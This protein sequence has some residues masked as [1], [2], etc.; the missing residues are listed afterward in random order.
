VIEHAALIANLLSMPWA[1]EQSAFNRLLQIADR[2]ARGES[3]SFSALQE[4]ADIKA[5]RNAR[6]VENRQITGGVG[7][8]PIYGVIMQRAS[9]Y[10]DVSGLVSTQQISAQLQTAL[11]DT[12]VASIVLEFDSPGGSVFGIQ[13]LADEIQLATA[14]K[15]VIGIANSLAASAA[16]WLASQ[17]SELYCTP[18][19]STGSIGVYVT[20]E[21]WS[22]A[23]EKAGV[24]TTII[25]AGKYKT[26]ASEL[27]P[28]SAD[29]K[30]HLQH[31]VDSYYQTFI[32]Q[33]GRGRNLPASTVRR[34]MGEGRVLGAADARAANMIDGIATFGQVINRARQA[35]PGAR[36]GTFAL[37]DDTSTAHM[38][39]A[40]ARSAALAREEELLRLEM[41]DCDRHR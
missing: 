15:P 39:S 10:D 4:T 5:A 12:S 6:R 34:G 11:A 17:C 40:R 3:P 18:S 20:H 31:M 1:L 13:E 36:A 37:L 14:K 30:D 8:I 19:G 26:E 24:A 38:R 32:A 33:V 25:A 9:L 27:Q 7:V 28:L 29:A 22:R 21:D 2:V 23:A 41:E 35:K 16:Y